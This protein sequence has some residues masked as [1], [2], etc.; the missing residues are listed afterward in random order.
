MVRRDILLAGAGGQG[1]LFFG[2]ILS[3][4]AVQKG[5]WVITTPSYGA[6]V[7]GGEVKCG[8]II[9]DEEIEDPV[10]DKADIAVILNEA[11]LKKFGPKVNQGGTLLYNSTENADTIVASLERECQQV[12]IPL[13]ALGP[14]LYHNMIA[15]GALLGIAPDL[16]GGFIDE[17]LTKEMRKRGREELIEENL[18]FIRIGSEWFQRERKK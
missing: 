6:S 8:V 14:K 16:N 18:K 13:S 10:V 15:L 5:M 11:S 12:S 17:A 3:L 1:I 2:N 9:S 4:A 7:R